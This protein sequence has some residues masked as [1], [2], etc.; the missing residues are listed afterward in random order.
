[1]LAADLAYPP[2]LFNVALVYSPTELKFQLVNTADSN[3]VVSEAN[4][5]DAA[6]GGIEI[7]GTDGSD[8]LR[9]DVDSLTLAGATTAITFLGSGDDSVAVTADANFLLTGS[10]LTVGATTFT[11]AGFERAELTGGDSSNTFSFGAAVAIGSVAVDGG[12]DTDFFVGSDGNNNWRLTG[13]GKGIVG[14]VSFANI[15]NL[16]GGTGDDMCSSTRRLVA[17]TS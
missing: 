4:A 1:M 11:L 10:T 9:L 6:V 7:R 15:E 5:S 17:R 13:K 8:V 3:R 12:G 14:A 16:V 2:D